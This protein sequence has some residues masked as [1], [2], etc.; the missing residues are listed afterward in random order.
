MKS[1]PQAS[2]LYFD[3]C[4]FYADERLFPHRA[5]ISEGSVA[6]LLQLTVQV[7][8]NSVPQ[9]LSIGVCS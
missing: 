9:N 7:L 2:K 4:H 3:E 6:F 5:G 8:A 1:M